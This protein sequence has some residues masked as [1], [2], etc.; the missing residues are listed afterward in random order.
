MTEFSLQVPPEKVLEAAPD[1]MIVV[2]QSGRIA[3]INGESE[4]LFGYNRSE[5][6]GQWI[7]I[8]IPDAKRRDH[9]QSR[10]QY[11][12][13]PHPRAMGQM[14]DIQAL[15]KD[16]SVFSADI[17]L[18][19][20]YTESGLCVTAAVRDIT[21]QKRLH[22]K[23]SAHA[24]H[25]ERLQSDL[26]KKNRELEIQNADLEQ[27]AYVSSHDL[28]EPLR[29]ILAFGDRL[30][31]RSQNALDE[32][33]LDYLERMQNAA[34]RMSELINDLLEFSRLSTRG[35]RFE[36]VDLRS[37]VEHV[38]SDLEVQLEKT[39]MRIELEKLGTV[40]GD[41]TQLRQLM[42][43][44]VGNAI[45]FRRADVQPILK[46]G[47]KAVQEEDSKGRI[48]NMYEIFV[49]DNG[50]GIEPRFLDRIF[51][52]FERLHSRS[53]YEGTGIGLAICKKIA[54]RHDGKIWVE[55]ELGKGSKF[56]VRLPVS[57]LEFSPQ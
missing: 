57:P 4:K 32:R 17:K 27:F 33:A 54:E 14:L 16:G 19:P 23:L 22:E 25:L 13:S 56:V 50:I 36:T 38:L 18:S 37:V 53:D 6:I 21:E 43:N 7:E 52:V 30:R 31:Q 35:R 28:Q 41:A 3:Y 29:K 24:A 34:G 26:S 10:N 47:G 45:K 15:R 20:L 40:F 51:V 11:A 42:Q 12:Q 9:L 5:L 44:L 1:A 48:V 49:E 39:G 8:L 2:E 46:I 55:S